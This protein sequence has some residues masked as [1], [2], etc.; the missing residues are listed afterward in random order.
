MS[1]VSTGPA[2]DPVKIPARLAVRMIQLHEGPSIHAP[3]PVARLILAAGGMA[4]ARVDTLDAAFLE[5]L[6]A[7]VP[8]LA[9][10]GPSTASATVPT[11][12]AR[13]ALALQRGLRDM[14]RF[15]GAR[16]GIAPGTIDV[17]FA[18]RYQGIARAA[19]QA[20]PALV[21]S[22]ADPDGAARG[23]RALAR[24]HAAVETARPGR[25]TRLLRDAAVARGI[26][27]RE[28]VPG[29]D[30]LA[31]G[32]GRHARYI[33][34]SVTE[35]TPYISHALCQDKGATNRILRAAGIPAPA[36]EAVTREAE[37][38]AAAGRIGYPVVVKPPGESNGRGVAI[39][40]G[41]AAAV[42]AAFRAA[43]A[44]AR[45][46]LV[47]AMVPGDEHRLL[48]IAGR[49]VTAS[50]RIPASIVG[51]G[52]RSIRALVDEANRH[53]WRSDPLLYMLDLIQID[54]E[55]ERWLARSGLTLDHVP[56]AGVR[57]LLRGNSNLSTGGTPID[58]TA[59]VH[60]SIGHLAERA[61]AL[62]GLATTGIDYITTD[63]ARPPW[64][65]GGAVCEVNAIPG[66]RPHRATER[67]VDVAARLVEAAFPRGGDGRIPTAAVTGTNGK[68]TTC[69][70]VAAILAAAG[71]T[72][73]LA[74][75]DGVEIAGRPVAVGDRAGP[76]GARFVLHD[77]TVDAAVLEAA[78]GGLVKHG[79]GVDRCHV[80]AVTNLGSDHVGTDGIA[81]AAMLARVKALVVET[82]TDL[83]VLDAED[84][85]VAALASRTRARLCWIAASAAHPRVREA[86]DAGAAA[87]TLVDAAAGPIL[88]LW[89][90]DRATALLPAAAIPATFGGT[91]GFN[92]RNALFAAA[93]ARGLGMDDAAIRA[94]LAG[95]AA[96]PGTTPGRANLLERGDGAR[97]LVDYGH[98][99][100]AVAAVSAWLSGMAVSGRRICLFNSP[101]DRPDAHFT[102][103]AT[104]VAPHFD[105]FVCEPGTNP[106]GRDPRDTVTRFADGLAAAGVAP[107]RIRC[108]LAEPEAVAEALG[109]LRPGDLAVLFVA[110]YERTL[111]QVGAAGFAS[112]A[113]SE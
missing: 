104:A 90:G 82:A 70:M 2:A 96:G 38:V 50:R 54:A 25:I 4:L 30:M 63:I 15:G 76:D 12:L 6:H 83:A 100:E 84:E 58:V 88:T 34:R 19:A 81:D 91:A 53:P 36:Q 101:G 86:L 22:A 52:T 74:T 59:D 13:V 44:Y 110:D 28:P 102:R 33:H 37:A 16:A 23:A 49:F 56:A 8:E 7:W 85:A 26:P 89:D 66:H 99:P 42:A 65:A 94:G 29:Q 78:R 97:V 20:A 43:Q 1:A 73:G 47:E 113:P 98:N 55:S 57:V 87:A 69:R 109:L 45:T 61:A 108:A 103:L 112:P 5:R 111:A 32:H 75:T 35:T 105:A 77:R 17:V 3:E 62:F 48:V 9:A 39:D 27:V 64:E 21:E 18:Y 92:V 80:G 95:F 11:V 40:L 71:R 51:D 106:R 14:V 24:F 31:L 79:L 46:T 93:I 68:T 107:D 41:D 10:P 72:V 60:P 67:P